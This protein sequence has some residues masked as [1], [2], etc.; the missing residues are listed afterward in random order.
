MN[1]YKPI[2]VLVVFGPK[3]LDNKGTTLYVPRYYIVR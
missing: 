3:R 1:C 2:E